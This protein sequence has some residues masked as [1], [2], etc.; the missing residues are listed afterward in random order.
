MEN[1]LWLRKALNNKSVNKRSELPPL[2]KGG[3]FTHRQLT[4]NGVKSHRVRA[5]D[6]TKSS[7]YGVYLP[8]GLLFEDEQIMRSLQSHYPNSWAS[9]FSAA[10]FHGLASPDAPTKDSV[11]LSTLRGQAK[12]RRRGIASYQAVNA[13]RI[14]FRR[15]I[16]W[17]S[18]ERTV[19]E[20]ARFSTVEEVVV[21]I[22][23]LIREPRPELEHR[24]EPLVNFE[25]WKALLPSWR[26]SGKS[27]LL[28]AT[29]LARVGSD[30]PPET[31]LRLAILNAGLPE[32]SL[33]IELPAGGWPR[34]SA[35]MGYEDLKIAVHYDGATHR[36]AKQQGT[37]NWRDNSFAR[38]GWRNLR[39]SSVDL[40][41]GFKNTC[42]QLGMLIQEQR[43]VLG[44]TA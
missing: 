13:E 24:W 35:D 40:A 14:I 29:Q 41:N 4:A 30:S 18:P 23:Q 5:N 42:R 44:L 19:M 26:S 22:D 25:T 16:R 28:E 11:H 33:Q 9:H 7:I 20:L 8:E 37:D 2:I 27:K 3:A 12:I 36:S 10:K 21:M 39:C 1:S 15:G 31:R 17:S 6:I 38:L 34:P 43:N 32:P